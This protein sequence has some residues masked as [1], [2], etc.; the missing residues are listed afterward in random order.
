MKLLPEGIAELDPNLRWMIRK[1]LRILEE[2]AREPRGS[3][4]GELTLQETQRRMGDAVV[5]W[6]RKAEEVAIVDNLRVHIREWLRDF[7]ERQ[8]LTRLFERLAR[9]RENSGTHDSMRLP[10]HDERLRLAGALLVGLRRPDPLDTEREAATMARVLAGHGLVTYSFRR[11]A[12]VRRFIRE[13]RKSCVLFDALCDMVVE[14]QRWGE[15][16]PRQLARWRQKVAD[17]RL[18][19]PDAQPIPPQRPANPAQLAYEM[20]IQFTIEILRRLGVPPRGTPVSGCGI[21]AEAMGISEA[22]VVR[23]WKQCTW[24]TSFL[25]AMRKYSKAIAIRTGLFH[26]NRGPLLVQ[27]VA[28]PLLHAW[29]DARRSHPRCASP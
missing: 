23:I 29:A 26:P 25:P 21:V 9:R 1:H 2:A 22:T 4:T 13:C 16:I 19:R 5:R 27:A 18:R 28:H 11:R 7:A 8:L 20:Q 6:D 14:W 15:P 24:R 17:G 12:R 10:S 3:G